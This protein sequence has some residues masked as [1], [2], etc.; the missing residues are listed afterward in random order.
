MSALGRPAKAWAPKET[1]LQVSGLPLVPFPS[2]PSWGHAPSA[3]PTQCAGGPAGELR[4][5]G[6]QPPE[7]Q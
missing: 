3:G 7:V 6:A 5:S 2:Q 4:H 1:L